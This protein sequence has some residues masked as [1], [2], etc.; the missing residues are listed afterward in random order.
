MPKVLRYVP[1]KGYIK[2]QVLLTN[3]DKAGHEKCQIGMCTLSEGLHPWPSLEVAIYKIRTFRWTRNWNF[4]IHHISNSRALT[5]FPPSSCVWIRHDVVVKDSPAVI[6]TNELG[7][8]CAIL[9]PAPLSKGC[10]RSARLHVTYNLFSFPACAVAGKVSFYWDGSAALLSLSFSASSRVELGRV[11]FHSTF[12]SN[13]RLPYLPFCE[14]VSTWIA[15]VLVGT[16]HMPAIGEM[17]RYCGGTL[18]LGR[19]RAGRDADAGRPPDVSS[20]CE[21]AAQNFGSGFRAGDQT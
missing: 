6:Y 16:G 21:E 8:K 19:A 5:L 15:A 10:G 13:W 1:C 14:N 18:T 12:E 11:S 7:L 17:P 2:A 20:K 9:T 3:L 4:W